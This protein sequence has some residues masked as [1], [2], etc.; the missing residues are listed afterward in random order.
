MMIYHNPRCSKSRQA[1]AILEK[2]AQEHGVTFEKILYLENP[3]SA[4]EIELICKKLMLSPK[5]LVR[6]NEAEYKNLGHV[7]DNEWS[8]VLASQ[9][10]L[11]QR[12]IVVTPTRAV[13]GRPPEAILEIL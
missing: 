8:L 12:P 11:M 1:L 13:I 6:T 5:E 4:I 3:L 10:R 2:Y 7:H 9:P